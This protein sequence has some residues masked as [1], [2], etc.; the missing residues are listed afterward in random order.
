MR[1][2]R[3]QTVEYRSEK[4][5]LADQAA[6]ARTA[7]VRTLEEMKR[8]LAQSA[9]VR[10]CARLHP[11]I[12]TGSAAV[13][14]FVAGA[15]VSSPRSTSGERSPAGTEADAPPDSTGPE[16]ARAKAGFLRATLGTAL[17]GILQSL[18][19]SVITAAVVAQEVEPAKE[20]SQPR[21]AA[22]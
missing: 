16:P 3:T 1:T 2:A 17:T 12:A 19:Q 10:T 20:E 4:R 6:D 7:M 9:D 11:W 13:A 5:F 14:G 21:N 18:L 8:T 22:P 15:V